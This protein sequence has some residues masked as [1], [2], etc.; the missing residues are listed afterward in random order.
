MSRT[1]TAA[2]I[3][4]MLMATAAMAEEA[5]PS[6]DATVPAPAAIEPAAAP[7]PATVTPEPVPAVAAPAAA[8]EAPVAESP[9]PV[10]APPA[11]PAA[12]PVV[13]RIAPCEGGPYCV[14]TA[15]HEEGRHVAPI[16]YSG[17][18][19]PAQQAMLRI[20]SRTRDAQVV[21]VTPG[22]IRVEFHSAVMHFIDDLEMVFGNHQIQVRASRRVGLY[23][24][25][26]NRSRV[27]DLRKAFED[28]Q[29]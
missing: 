13:H 1:V 27:E 11:V 8:S 21:E 25:G 23:D 22:Y 14:S 4:A 26:V 5:V 18:D 6:A 17:S 28:I 10:E 12:A 7:V 9:A 16:R 24:F 19:A 29:P 15:S 3:S 2:L 20:L